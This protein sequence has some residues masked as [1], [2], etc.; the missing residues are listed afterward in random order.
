[1]HHSHGW[2]YKRAPLPLATPYYTLDD[3]M[4]HYYYVLV[5]SLMAALSVADAFKLDLADE[6]DLD[7]DRME[8]NEG[9]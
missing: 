6:E 2:V 7:L 8:M 1:M 4:K 5:L 9:M 3:M